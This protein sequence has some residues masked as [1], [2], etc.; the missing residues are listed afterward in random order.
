MIPITDILPSALLEDINAGLSENKNK[1]TKLA[2]MFFGE[3]V[4]DPSDKILYETTGNREERT[5]H[6]YKYGSPLKPLTKSGKSYL[7]YDMLNIGDGYIVDEKEYKRF[8]D[9]YINIANTD[10]FNQWLTKESIKLMME[11]SNRIDNQI[12]N[13]ARSLILD[14]KVVWD[15][16][17]YLQF[18]IPVANNKGAVSISSKDMIYYL[19]DQKTFLRDEYGIVDNNFVLAVGQGAFEKLRADAGVN[20]ELTSYATYR[21]NAGQ[22]PTEQSIFGLDYYGNELKYLP[23]IDLPIMVVQGKLKVKKVDTVFGTDDW[24]LLPKDFGEHKFK[25]ANV[26]T[27]TTIG[28]VNDLYTFARSLHEE[29]KRYNLQVFQ[30]TFRALY[31]K[32]PNSLI[33]GTFTA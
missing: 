1:T 31:P 18:D 26:A 30:E 20:A 9:F 6:I 8:K 2:N 33:K 5:S 23:N 3:P 10:D 25:G 15:G 22:I 4:F 16:E 27:D 11:M 19:D 17:D 29:G 21:S 32:N 24:R 28:K 12:E 14:Q 7:E 13:I